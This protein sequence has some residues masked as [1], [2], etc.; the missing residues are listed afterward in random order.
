MCVQGNLVDSSRDAVGLTREPPVIGLGERRK[1]LSIECRVCF[2]M[3]QREQAFL[4]AMLVV[5]PTL[6]LARWLVRSVRSGKDYIPPP[7][8]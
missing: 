4:P 2:C 1:H 7:E 8:R 5:E 3:V 6:Q